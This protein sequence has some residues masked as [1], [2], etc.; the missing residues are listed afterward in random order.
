MC[1][2]CTYNG[3]NVKEAEVV[4]TTTPTHTDDM[5]QT[6]AF[7]RFDSSIPKGFTEKLITKFKK[8]AST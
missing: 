7:R 3:K 2:I 5:L 8:C 1:T 4:R 6:A